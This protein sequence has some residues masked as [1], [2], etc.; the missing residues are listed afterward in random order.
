[1]LIVTA[2]TF[3]C[4]KWDYVQTI[5]L[6]LSMYSVLLLNIPAIAANFFIV[7][8]VGLVVFAYYAKLGCDPLEN[9]D[10]S[11]PN[12]VKLLTSLT[13]KMIKVILH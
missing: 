11:N 10:V 3:K 13:I 12:Q 6:L 2:L 4:C 1:M 9:K 7:C 5:Y 8:S